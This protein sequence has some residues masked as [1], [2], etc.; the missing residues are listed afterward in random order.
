MTIFKT[1]KSDKYIQTLSLDL[2]KEFIDSYWVDIMERL[3]EDQVVHIIFK[4]EYQDNSF[5]SFSNMNVITNNSRPY[6]SKQVIYDSVRFYILNNLSHYEQLEV[7]S[8]LF[9]YTLSDFNINHDSHTSLRTFINHNQIEVP[10]LIELSETSL[11]NVKG[12]DFLP[13]TMSLRL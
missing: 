7:K 11:E 2:V 8:I 13:K 4:V 9:S 12:Y 3:N 1:Y 10:D 6:G 5:R